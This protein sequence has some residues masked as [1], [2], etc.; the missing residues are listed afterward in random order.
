[1][2]SPNYTDVQ[3]Y[4][5]ARYKVHLWLLSFASSTAVIYIYITKFVIFFITE[6]SRQGRVPKNRRDWH[7]KRA[8]PCWCLHSGAMEGAV[9]GSLRGENDTG[10][11]MN[12]KRGLEPY[13]DRYL[14]IEYAGMSDEFWRC[15][16]HRI[17]TKD[18]QSKT[19]LTASNLILSGCNTF[20]IVIQNQCIRFYM[21]AVKLMQV[22][23]K[24]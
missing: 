4:S 9:T 22:N 5:F 21:Y 23:Y 10:V 12:R 17:K 14:W 18:L 7:N 3:W 6:N 11:K 20:Y 13:I 16:N 19:F 15:P 24:I 8:I 2:R 1:M